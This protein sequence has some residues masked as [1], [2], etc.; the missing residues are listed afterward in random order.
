MVLGI[1]VTENDLKEFRD[2]LRLFLNVT[3]Q[4]TIRTEKKDLYQKIQNSIDDYLYMDEPLMATETAFAL[5]GLKTGVMLVSDD[6]FD[7]YKQYA[8]ITIPELP[9]EPGFQD[10]TDEFLS[11]SEA[12][13]VL[14]QAR[15]IQARLAKVLNTATRHQEE[16]PTS[17]TKEF[18]N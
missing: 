9:E 8:T 6:H 3:L 17:E 15:G 1:S 12:N 7:W 11:T 16:D 5:N 13:N 2:L 14:T 18:V 10:V 4:N